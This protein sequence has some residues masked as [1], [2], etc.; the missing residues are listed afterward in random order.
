[1]AD[2]RDRNLKYG[3]NRY[4]FHLSP[5]EQKAGVS[6]E[7]V[8]SQVVV[9]V[10][11]LVGKTNQASNLRSNDAAYCLAVEVLQNC[12]VAIQ[13]SLDNNIARQPDAE[14]IESLYNTRTF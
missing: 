5:A 14:H 10:N 4:G 7:F 3:D 6:L 13:N 2:A 1:M 11:N 8:H 9:P 12:S